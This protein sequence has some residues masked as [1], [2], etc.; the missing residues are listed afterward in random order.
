MSILSTVTKPQDRPIIGTITGDAGTG[1][2]TLAATFPKPIFIRIEDGLQSIPAD[3]RPDAFPV[4]SQVDDLWHQLKALIT[5]EHDY[6]TLV[7]DSITQLETLFAEH[8]IESD[9]KSPKSLAQANGGYGAGYLA[10]SAL[11]GRVRKAAKMLN[12]KRGMNV[13]FIAH[14]DVTTI[15]LPDADP[16][17]RYELRLHKKC[18]PHYVDNVDLVAYLKL[19]TFTTGDGDRKK[20]ISSGNRIA[21]CYTGAAQ[22]SKNRYGITE[23]L[24]VAQGEN[25]FI[26]FISSLT[27]SK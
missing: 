24:P 1:K 6:K 13:V 20:A 23:D 14:S 26:P 4:V 11:H 2:T 22:V 15:E 17:S 9:P 25:P 10:V 12:E 21:V 18:V 5:D 16:Y 8:V 27:E 7:L 3:Q 19:E